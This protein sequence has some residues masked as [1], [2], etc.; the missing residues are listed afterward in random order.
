MKVEV[1]ESDAWRRT[2]EIEVPREDVN[3]RLKE[4]YKSYSKSLNLPG[5]RKGKVP[6]SVVKARFG[7][8]ILDEVIAKT[9]EEFYREASQ[10]QGLHPVSQ[11]TI[12]DSS[13]EDGEPLKFKASVDVK[14]ELDIQNYKGLKVVRPVFKFE[15]SFV[16]NQLN[17]M[18]EQNATEKQVD[19]K[20]E[21]GDVIQADYVELDE[22]GEE[23]AEKAQQDRVFLIGGPNANHDLDNQLVG[24]EIGDTRDVQYT[25]SHDTEDGEHHNHEVRFRVT[26]KEIRERELPELDDDFAKDVGPFESLED[27]KTRIRDDIQ[28]Q[29]DTASRSRLVE[30]LV[31]ELIAQNEFEVPNSMVETYLDNF[32]EQVKRERQSEEL[33]NEDEI[34]GNAREGAL[35][36]VKRYLILEQVAEK[37]TVEVS[38]EDLD[39]HLQTMSERH[40]VDGERIRQILGRSG[41]LERIKS[42]LLDEKVFD[43]LIENAKV[44]DVEEAPN[45]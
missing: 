13:F 38:E 22:N 39:K 10:E 6:V 17:G 2:L 37:E 15:E 11:A 24:I 3:E 12:E 1:T 28:A 33:P 7:P 5:F 31:E 44:D 30:N 8:A 40:N 27:L 19:R 41:Q 20:A 23:V 32:V 14:P 26:A 36:G 34:R 25:H 9:E 45:S 21:L 35:R 4:A 29:S 16:E 42:D 43:F 18:R